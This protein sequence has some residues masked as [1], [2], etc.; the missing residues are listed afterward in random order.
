MNVFNRKK[1]QATPQ[2]V[3]LLTPLQELLKAENDV[4]LAQA[5][6]DALNKE[7]LDWHHHYKVIEDQNGQFLGILNEHLLSDQLTENHL[8]DQLNQFNARKND[9]LRKF[10]QKLATWAELKQ[11]HSQSEKQANAL[12]I[13]APPA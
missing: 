4:N 3:P 12:P 1:Q 7:F 10:H 11:R 8:K 2:A 5:D 6:I 9:L 13:L